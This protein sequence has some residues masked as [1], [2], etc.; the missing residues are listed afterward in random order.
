MKKLA[1]M[2]LA[3]L[4]MVSLACAETVLRMYFTPSEAFRQAH[5]EVQ[6]EILSDSRSEDELV[7]GLKAG[8]L[9]EDVV[10]LYTYS[11]DVADLIDQGLFLDLSGNKGI[12]EAVGRM[13]PA[14]Q[15]LVTR[16]GAIYG[17][18]YSSAIYVDLLG[19]APVWEELGYTAADVPQTFPALLDFLE[20]YAARCE[21]EPMTYSVLES[22]DVAV[23]NKY[24]YTN[25]LV[26]YLL[27]SWI[28]QQQ[29]AGESIRFND[30]ELT[31]L[32]ERCKQVGEAIYHHCPAG[33]KG[34]FL[35]ANGALGY[36][37]DSMGDWFV[38]MRVS[39]EQ[40]SLIVGGG[41]VLAAPVGASEP[42]LVAELML[43][44]LQHWD[45]QAAELGGTTAAMLYAD[46]E[47]VPRPQQAGNVRRYRNY[48]AI[49][50]HLLAGDN[51]PLEDYLELEESDYKITKAYDNYS[52]MSGYQGFAENMKKLSK[53]ELKEKLVELQNRLA[54]EEED[55]WSFSPEGLAVYKQFAQEMRVQKP[56]FHLSVSGAS[57]QYS[58]L[59]RD[60]VRNVISVEQL[61]E[62]LDQVAQEAELENP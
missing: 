36:T 3:G 14:L 15:E 40:P 30:P 48:I 34:L 16:D 1:A 59:V 13:H 52:E 9:Q 46:A 58:K 21:R 18:P 26:R 31:G 33:G 28:G 45:I 57:E 11:M 61:V 27:D 37:W 20:G 10:C 38:D 24:T 12:R 17:V 55:A 35:F 51:T 4:M 53:E 41:T 49:V 6:V 7:K 39:E 44:E 5:P 60:Y 32:L 29:Y 42:E 23:Y 50:E 54:E 43:T 56:S 62:G 8:T 19:N 47:P 2:V 22:L 25:D